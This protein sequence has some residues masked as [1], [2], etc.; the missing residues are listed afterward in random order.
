MTV[1]I[2]ATTGWFENFLYLEGRA[3]KACIRRI[4]VR[5]LDLIEARFQTNAPQKVFDN[6]ALP[7]PLLHVT[8]AEEFKRSLQSV[9]RA[10]KELVGGLQISAQLAGEVLLS[11]GRWEVD[12]LGGDD[13]ETLGLESCIADF[14]HRLA[15]QHNARARC[16]QAANL[17]D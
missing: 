16:R 14:V 9:D 4:D 5:L 7:S 12:H 6:P 17:V 13:I 3:S 2:A 1:L 8:R 11:T 15:D 10:L